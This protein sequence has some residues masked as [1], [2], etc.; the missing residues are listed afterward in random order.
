MKKPK[1]SKKATKS[2]KQT[3][4]AAKLAKKAAGSYFLN[5]LQEL[6]C[7]LSL[8]NHTVTNV[9]RI[10]CGCHGYTCNDHGL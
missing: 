8:D 6:G 3:K 10:L 2:P 4:V 9:A 1:R 5:E 7:Y